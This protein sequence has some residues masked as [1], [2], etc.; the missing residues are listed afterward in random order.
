MTGASEK[1]LSIRDLSVAFSPLD[2]SAPPFEAVAGVSM[3]IDAGEVVCIVGPSGCGKSTILNVVAGMVKTTWKTDAKITGTV[4]M[5]T[6]ATERNRQFGYTNGANPDR[7]PLWIGAGIHAD[8]LTIAFARNAA[9]NA[10]SA[11]EVWLGSDGG[12]FRSPN[13][14]PGSFAALNEGLAITQPTYF[15]HHPTSDAIVLC[16]TQDNGTVRGDGILANCENSST[17]PLRDS[18]SPTMVLVHSS[19]TARDSPDAL[20]MCRRMRSAD[21]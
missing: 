2:S 8:C 20:D 21:S 12:V 1:L 6:K 17:S 10:L 4:H 18:T 9:G 7:S 19:M 13:G 3:S 11:G 5:T 16:G 14:T 15:D